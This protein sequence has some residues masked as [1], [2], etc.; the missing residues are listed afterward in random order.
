VGKR[1]DLIVVGRN[2]PHQAPGGDPFS[3]LVYAT[4]GHD[5]RLTVVDGQ[6]L[7]SNGH[8][9]TIDERAAVAAASKEAAALVTRAARYMG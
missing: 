9:V 5:V 3:T 2:Q 8:T 6:V 7:V 1:A 4:R